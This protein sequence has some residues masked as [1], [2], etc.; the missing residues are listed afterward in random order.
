VGG[1]R[2]S[3]NS[4]CPMPNVEGHLPDQEWRS[5]ARQAEGIS[6]LGVR[7]WAFDVRRAFRPALLVLACLCRA[8]TA[9]PPLHPCSPPASPEK[10]IHRLE[11]EVHR[12]PIAAPPT[13]VRGVPL[14]PRQPVLSREVLG[15]Y[16]YWVSG[17]SDL[18]WD[19]LSTVAYFCADVN[20][21]GSLGDLHGWPPAELISEAHLHGVRVAL[22]A[23]CFSSSS[24]NTLLSTATYRTAL[25]NNLLGQ[26]EGAGADGVNIDF[27]GVPGSQKQNLTSFFWELADSFHTGI[28]TAHVTIATPAVDWQNAFDYSELAFAG[29]GLMVMGYDYHW[30]GSGT[31][32]PVAP[33][34]GWGTY[35]VTWTVDDYLYWTG[36]QRDKII[37]G[38]PYYGYEW[39]CNGPEPGSS[40]TG[41][42]IAKTFRVAEPLAQSVGKLWDTP[43]S[44]PWYRF[45]VSPWRQGW[46][47]DWQSLGMKYDLVNAE[48]LAGSGI[49]ALCYD[50]NRVEMWNALERYYGTVPRRARVCNTGAGTIS[51]AWQP[52][53]GAGSY[54]LFHSLDGISFDPGITVPGGEVVIDTIP[55]GELR[56]F[57]LASTGPWGQSPAGEVLGVRVSV[58]ASGLL[59]VNGFDRTWG[60]NTRDFVIQHGG[61]AQRLGYAFDCCS[62]EAVL[63]GDVQLTTYSAVDWILG[64][65]GVSD[66]SFSWGEQQ[67][68]ANYLDGGGSL[69]VSGSEVGYDLDYTGSA[70]DQAFYAGY[71]RAQYVVDD[72][73][74]YLA[75]GVSGSCLSGLSPFSF[76]DG[77]HGTYDVAYPDAI[78]GDGGGTECC[79]YCGTSWYAGVQ[80]AGVF[81]RGSRQGRLLY[82]AFPFETVYVDAERDS[83]AARAL[84]FLGVQPEPD[85]VPPSAVSD[86]GI[87]AEGSNAVLSWTEVLTD[88]LGGPET[89]AGY[90]VYRS[91]QADF[92]A[93]HPDSVAFVQDPLYSDV[94]AAGVPAANHYYRVRAVDLAWNRAAPSNT[95][96][97]FDFGTETAEGVRRSNGAR[98]PVWRDSG[99]G[100]W[101]P[102]G[103]C[104]GVR[105]E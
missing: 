14:R 82:L 43:S 89:V 65:E 48:D 70:D 59:M 46:Y 87:R 95:V 2:L 67:I 11:W 83:V 61:S 7:S 85:I 41:T 35:N 20:A 33:L 91:S 39:P 1:P 54:L 58:C 19:L 8:A 45:E 96:G 93:E 9:D 78:M 52:V 47:D 3:P 37:L 31:T 25:V 97:E 60:G 34:Q 5:H 74:A 21:D 23:T 80:Y 105:P 38:V 66:E 63:E 29:E 71:L 79:R 30:S 90:V 73:G 98:E 72:A 55:A 10:S 99:V 18:R 22:V 53:F 36:Y 101:Y 88:T 17:Y 27:E 50:S 32:G 51:V 4:E 49:W 44:T 100:L 57:K 56:F 24:I 84:A 13:G 68:V 81:P 103:S 77:S 42:G 104:V 12:L 28:P 64:N 92:P 86:L 16:P 6:E 76:D 94:G 69:L 102:R 75:E 15:Y 62:N 40:T 26:V